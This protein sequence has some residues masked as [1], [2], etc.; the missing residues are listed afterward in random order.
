LSFTDIS[1]SSVFLGGGG[2]GGILGFPGLLVYSTRS[3]MKILV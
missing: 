2:G 1:L 3:G